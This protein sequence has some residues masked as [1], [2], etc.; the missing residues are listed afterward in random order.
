MKI[1]IILCL[2]FFIENIYSQ[3]PNCKKY[4]D[5]G[6]GCMICNDNYYQYREEEYYTICKS[7]PSGKV[8]V[9]GIYSNRNIGK[10]RVKPE[11]C[12]KYYDEGLGCMVCDANYYGVKD[13]L[14]E[15]CP[16][17]KFSTAGLWVNDGIDS[18]YVAKK[19]RGGGG[20]VDDDSADDEVDDDS[21]DDEVA[22][23]SALS[24]VLVAVVVAVTAA[25]SAAWVT[26]L[27]CRCLKKNNCW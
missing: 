23:E 13:N 4:F 1:Q 18:C 27:I 5:E 3:I 2:F 21:A 15:S 16:S 11:N 7:C 26:W 24:R 9:A 12:K 25:S 14:C 17:G 20:V 19:I 6:L 8:S 22:A 10:C